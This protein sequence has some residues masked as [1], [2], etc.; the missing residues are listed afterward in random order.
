[1]AKGDPDI[2]PRSSIHRRSN[3]MS[4]R[5]QA[6]LWMDKGRFCHLFILPY[7]LNA[8]YFTYVMQ[9]SEHTQ[10]AVLSFIQPSPFTDSLILFTHC[11][12]GILW[13]VL[14]F[15]CLSINLLSSIHR[16]LF[17]VE[18]DVF[19]EWIR[20]VGVLLIICL[21]FWET[22]TRILFMDKGTGRE[23]MNNVTKHSH[24]FFFFFFSN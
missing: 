18:R 14:S 6:M 20:G 15:I 3:I 4:R 7:L 12:N 2:N 5:M 23:G 24:S 9:S 13:I 11:V 19:C 10:R 21:T 22:N 8:Y 1:M 17:H 16:V